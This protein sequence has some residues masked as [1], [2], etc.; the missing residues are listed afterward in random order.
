MYYFLN[1]YHFRRSLLLESVMKNPEHSTLPCEHACNLSEGSVPGN[2]EI[3]YKNPFEWSVNIEIIL[4]YDNRNQT[5][6]PVWKWN[7][8]QNI[9]INTV[10]KKYIPKKQQI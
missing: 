1:S 3:F 5:I 8:K 10:H 6:T 7:N 4:N 9:K 2:V